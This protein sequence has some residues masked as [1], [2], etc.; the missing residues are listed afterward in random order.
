MAE[1]TTYRLHDS[2]GY[3][4]S[5]TSRMQERRLDD[6]LRPLGLTRITWCILLAVENEGL[7]RPS[8]IADFVGIDRTATSRALRQM[9]EAGLISR[10][11]A[12]DDRRMTDVR[13]SD[14]GRDLMTRATPLAEENNRIAAARLSSEER[15]ELVR[16][17]AKSIE[18]AELGLNKL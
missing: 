17:L 3:Y 10:A 5:L 16:L 2:L 15:D 6:W 1:N 8:E 13:L 12:R 7:S 11:S 14:L 18:G 9:E 4:M